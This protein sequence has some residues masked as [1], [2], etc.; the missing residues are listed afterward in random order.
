[1][2]TDELDLSGEICPEPSMHS[3]SG[4]LDGEEGETPYDSFHE[5]RSSGPNSPV[6]H[7]MDS[8]KKFTGGDDREKGPLVLPALYMLLENDS[9]RDSTPSRR[10]RPHRHHSSEASP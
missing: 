5:G 10:L 9:T 1:M 8:V 2:D 7:T 4:D 3:G 6:F